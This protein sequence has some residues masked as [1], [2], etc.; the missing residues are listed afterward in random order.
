MLPGCFLLCTSSSRRKQPGS[1]HH[2]LLMAGNS[3][4]IG[5]LKKHTWVLY[6]CI[7]LW[8]H[9][10]VIVYIIGFESFGNMNIE[11]PN[12]RSLETWNQS[13]NRIFESLMLNPHYYDP[14]VR[15]CG[16][17]PSK[18]FSAYRAR[19]III[20][21]LYNFY[22]LFEVHLCTVTFGLMYG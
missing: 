16:Q 19:A 5:N 13:S 2:Y 22:P 9:Q 15:A 7:L 18:R 6:G 21:G 10:W 12:V 14:N 8:H 4:Q 1:T 20:R 17:K 3:H 11:S